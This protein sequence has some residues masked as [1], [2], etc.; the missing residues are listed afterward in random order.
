MHEKKCDMNSHAHKI[1]SLIN[2]ITKQKY[3]KLIRSNG[4]PNNYIY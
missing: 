3:P 2:S 4:Y 1:S